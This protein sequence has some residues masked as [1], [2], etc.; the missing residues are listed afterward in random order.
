MA[1]QFRDKLRAM[2]MAMSNES[3]DPYRQSLA[4][5]STRYNIAGS[6]DPDKQNVGGHKVFPYAN[7]DVD[8]PQTDSFLNDAVN[9]YTD[10]KKQEVQVFGAVSEIVR[11][12]PQW[13]DAE[14]EQFLN[15]VNNDYSDYLA[16]IVVFSDLD[17]IGIKYKRDL[18]ASQFGRDQNATKTQTKQSQNQ[19]NN[20]GGQPSPD[21]DDTATDFRSPGRQKK[22]THLITDYKLNY[23]N[24][25]KGLITEE[26]LK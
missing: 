23:P 10:P 15:K 14:R 9:R 22:R 4:V 25:K 12:N 1:T 7:L 3:F 24:I 21:N 11:S 6:G 8:D 18:N 19:N 20:R 5:E 13:T 2:D 17:K 16:N 26:D